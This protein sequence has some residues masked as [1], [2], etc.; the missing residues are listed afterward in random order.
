MY[1]TKGEMDAINLAYYALVVAIVKKCDSAKK[2]YMLLGVVDVQKEQ[3][4]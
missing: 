2:A 1:I 3:G 4:E